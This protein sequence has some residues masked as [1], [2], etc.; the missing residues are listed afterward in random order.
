[1]DLKNLMKVRPGDTV[2]WFE[3][4]AGER[5]GFRMTYCISRINYKRGL[6]WGKRVNAPLWEKNGVQLP[7]TQIEKSL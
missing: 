6:V 4:I 5:T 1:M 2:T 7:L 3:T